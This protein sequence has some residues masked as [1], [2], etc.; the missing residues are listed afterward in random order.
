[1]ISE[2]ILSMFIL[3][4]IGCSVAGVFMA[5]RWLYETLRGAYEP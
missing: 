4:V 1:M 3:G 2:F 5:G